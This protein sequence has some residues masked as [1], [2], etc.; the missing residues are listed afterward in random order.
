MTFRWPPPAETKNVK[1]G[2]K[3]HHLSSGVVSRGF[4][5]KTKDPDRS[6]PPSLCDRVLE[7]MRLADRPMTAAQIMA[8]LNRRSKSSIRDALNELADEWLIRATGR[9]QSNKDPR[10]WEIIK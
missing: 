5:G 10:F 7:V 8:A 1:P 2:L 3:M 6:A 9:R 4:S